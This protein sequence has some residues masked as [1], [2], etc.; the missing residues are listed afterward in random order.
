M[1]SVASVA[2]ISRAA[3]VAALASVVLL[4]ACGSSKSTTSSPSAANAHEDTARVARSIEQSILAQRHLPSKVVCPAA[5]PQEKG[6]I[7]ECIATTRTTK[8]PSKLVKT[9]FVVTVQNSRGYA[10][11]VGK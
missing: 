7:F 4:S 1:R 9:V 10:T 5:V 8:R 11:Y 2:P 3:A 6:R